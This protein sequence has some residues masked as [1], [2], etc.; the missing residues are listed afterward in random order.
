MLL[1]S[2]KNIKKINN[3]YSFGV[4]RSK[5]FSS[6]MVMH[7]RKLTKDAEF[8][9][10]L[11]TETYINLQHLKQRHMAGLVNF[12]TVVRSCPAHWSGS[13]RDVQGIYI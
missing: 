5:Q 1:I 8:S 4:I 6:Y 12:D 2:H 9:R 11:K 13:S 7:I 3:V 10:N